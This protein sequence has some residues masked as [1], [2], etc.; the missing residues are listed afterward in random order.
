MFTDANT[1]TQLRAEFG[2]AR[3]P[4]PRIV[5]VALGLAVWFG[6]SALLGTTGYLSADSDVPLRPILLSIAVPVAAFLVLY[7]RSATFRAFILSRDLRFVT[8]LQQWRVIGFAFI[9]L[10]A[11]GVLPGLFAWPAALGD[12]AVGLTTPLVLLALARRQGFVTS[13][14]FVAWNVLGL[15]DFVVAGTVAVL[16]SGAFPALLTGGPT[17]APMEVWPLILFPSFIVPLFVFAHL[18]VL[19]QVRAQRRL[20]AGQFGGTAASRPSMAPSTTDLATS[21]AVLRRSA[22]L[23]LVIGPSLVLVNQSGAVFGAQAF[24]LPAAALSFMTPFVVISIS[25]ALGIRAFFGER[26]AEIWNRERLLTTMRLHGIPRRGAL[27]AASVGIVVTA[28]MAA[29]AWLETGDPFGVPATQV[30]QVFVLPFAFGLV[31]QAAA[32]R[33]AAARA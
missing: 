17:S 22:V 2:P 14:T 20:T 9:L 31:S 15:L 24:S 16:A 6:V 28:L 10:Y 18:T 1:S 12:V 13:R 19:F 25:Q 27:V 33:R 21:P 23:A 11:Q 5:L 8:S 32:F 7:A 30:A 4:T 26:R 29:L 3:W